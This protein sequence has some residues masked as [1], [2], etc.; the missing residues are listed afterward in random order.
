[1]VVEYDKQN[2][3][4]KITRADGSYST[5]NQHVCVVM[6]A[7]CLPVLFCDKKASWVAA[8]HAGWRGLVD[9]IIQ[10][11]IAKYNG[12]PSDLMVWLGPAISQ[13]HFEVGAE[14]KKIFCDKNARFSKYFKP[15]YNGK[16][17]CDLYSIARLIL[18]EYSIETY[19]GNYCTFAD[20]N[21]FY[22]YRRDGETGR[23]A[24]LIW[25]DSSCGK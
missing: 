14:I 4:N 18:T 24:S 19:G 23:M 6:T 22:S 7:D 20:D 3:T 12:D 17:M 10:Q 16:F 1:E 21:R 9:G 8:I 2:T 11:T 5:K 25:I 13:K 15:A